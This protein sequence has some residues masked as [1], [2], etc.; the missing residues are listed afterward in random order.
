[1]SLVRSVIDAVR[2][3]LP[4]VVPGLPV[5]DTM[6]HV[7][8]AADSRDE[9]V[10]ATVDREALRVIQTPQGF[11]RALLDRA[12]AAASDDAAATDDAGLVER[13][14]ESVHV[15][16]GHPEALKI[17]HPL[18]VLIAESILRSRG[19]AATPRPHGDNDSSD[20]DG[21]DQDNEEPVA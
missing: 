1:M 14:G 18:D 2:S 12:F 8:V 11:D 4:A 9:I 20:H 16:P 6:K 19:A 13:L 21:S 5:T 3:G 10:G 17:T 7:H 15:I